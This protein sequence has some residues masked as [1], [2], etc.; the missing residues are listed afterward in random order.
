ML[1]RLIL[2][3]TFL[4]VTASASAAQYGIASVYSTGESGSRVG[5]RGYRLSNSALTAAMRDHRAHPCGSY[6]TVTNRRNGRI[7][8]VRIIDSGP[9]VRG[10][11]IDLTPA[12]ARA[13]GCGGLCPVTV[14]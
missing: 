11:I 6:V 12:A 9:Y 13:I 10:R 5:C 14:N 1:K 3:L 2:S 7:V 8:R 4:L